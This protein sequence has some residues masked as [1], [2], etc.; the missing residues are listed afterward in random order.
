VTATKARE[1]DKNWRSS[2]DHI[3]E[4]PGDEKASVHLASASASLANTSNTSLQVESEEDT[5]KDEKNDSKCHKHAKSESVGSCSSTEQ[6]KQLLDEYTAKAHPLVIEWPRP[7]RCTLIH[8]NEEYVAKDAE[9]RNHHPV[10]FVSFEK[11]E[12]HTKGLPSYTPRPGPFPAQIGKPPSTDHCAYEIR[13]DIEYYPESPSLED[14]RIR[15][16]ES[17]TLHD[18]RYH[19]NN[20]S[21][22]KATAAKEE[23]MHTSMSLPDQS[24]QY[25]GMRQSDLFEPNS[26]PMQSAPAHIQ[27]FSQVS[28]A[29]RTG[30]G[31]CQQPGRH[32]SQESYRSQPSGQASYQGTNYFGSGSYRRGEQ[33]SGSLYQPPSPLRSSSGPVRPYKY[34]GPA[35]SPFRS[36]FAVRHPSYPPQPQGVVPANPSPRVPSFPYGNGDLE[37]FGFPTGSEMNFDAMKESEILRFTAQSQQY[38][39]SHQPTMDPSRLPTP[40]QYLGSNSSSMQTSDPYPPSRPASHQSAHVLLPGFSY[41]EPGNTGLAMENA[42]AFS[43]SFDALA[44]QL[45]PEWANHDSAR[46]PALDA[47]YDRLFHSQSQYANANKVVPG[48]RASPVRGRKPHL[49]PSASQ[50]QSR[51]LWSDN[52][53]KQGKR[54]LN[55]QFSPPKPRMDGKNVVKVLDRYARS[56]S[57]QSQGP[58]SATTGGVM[59]QAPS[60]SP[61]L[62]NVKVA[63]PAKQNAGSARRESPTPSADS[64]ASNFSDDFILQDG[65]GKSKS[66]KRKAKINAKKAKAGAG[67]RGAAMETDA[68]KKVAAEEV[69]KNERDAADARAARVMR[70][71]SGKVGVEAVVEGE[72]MMSEG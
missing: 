40:N 17:Q 64:T 31:D 35:L 63:F 53:S 19:G 15:P 3:K 12:E 61:S 49:V 65:G 6:I 29:G 44:R 67:K 43:Q 39:Y 66:Q 50:G 10:L 36:Q 13:N 11:D 1:E 32:A 72:A 37:N 7:P 20:S 30:S 42:N 71:S 68:V 45:G 38:H 23:A 48:P 57:Q 4:S 2:I 54:P 24:M 25:D 46:D 5:L 22:I 52:R 60:G 56:G 51:A 58:E 70:R 59:E 14:A 18:E 69:V 55:G 62:S 28:W 47:N 9:S 27:S 16:A 26:R 21:H 41:L 34:H 33:Q 8:L